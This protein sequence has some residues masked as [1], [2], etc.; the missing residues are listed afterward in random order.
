MHTQI[1]E[2]EHSGAG[3]GSK[4]NSILL[5]SAIMA[6][7][8]IHYIYNYIYYYTITDLEKAIFILS[9]T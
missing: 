2:W 4:F 7:I 1:A 3:G 5:E 6:S 8:Y 9:F